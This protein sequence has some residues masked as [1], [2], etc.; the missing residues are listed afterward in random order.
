MIPISVLLANT[1]SSW[2][3]IFRT[4]LSELGGLCEGYNRQK[5]K[6]LNYER[7][8]FPSLA[9]IHD[10]VKDGREHQKFLAH[11]NTALEAQRLEL[12]PDSPEKNDDFG[13]REISMD[14]EFLDPSTTQSD[15]DELQHAGPVRAGKR[16]STSYS[17]EDEKDVWSP[18]KRVK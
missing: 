4:L 16:K 2:S 13:P 18:S 15:N 1:D 5:L 9:D 17:N 6:V 11:L 7:T 12:D 10:E 3:A 8:S 14:P